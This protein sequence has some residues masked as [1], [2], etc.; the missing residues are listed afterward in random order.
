[1]N[2]TEA[3]KDMNFVERKLMLIDHEFLQKLNIMKIKL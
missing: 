3:K 1:V 2:G